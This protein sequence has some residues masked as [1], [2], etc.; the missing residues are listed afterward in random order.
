[1]RILETNHKPSDT[2]Q[3]I[4][5]QVLVVDNHHVVRQGLRSEIEKHSD[6]ELVGEA[7]NGYDAVRLAVQLRPDI[8]ILDAH[9]SG[10]NGIQVVRRLNNMR[11]STCQTQWPPQILVLSDHSDKQYIWSFLSA[12]VR[13]YLLKSEEMS[14]IV[15]GI[16]LLVSGQTILS[17]PVQTLL[18]ELIPTLTHELSVRE[19]DVL[20]LLAKGLT[21][22]AIAETLQISERAVRNHLNNTYRKVPIVRTRAEAVAWAWI[23]QL[24]SE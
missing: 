4:S 24:V 9:L 12:G 22:Q 15:A 6:I 2:S 13:G 18:I 8:L 11:L 17:N 23:N 1:M 16:R 5:I 3:A 20:K 19:I 14:Q 21:N 10:L 7:A